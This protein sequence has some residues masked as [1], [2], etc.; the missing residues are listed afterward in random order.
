[1]NNMK[2]SLHA[3][4][5][6]DNFIAD[7]LTSQ[8][9]VQKLLLCP[10]TFSDTCG[11]NVI[12]VLILCMLL[13]LYFSQEKIIAQHCIDK[14]KT[15]S[16]GIIRFFTLKKTTVSTW[17]LTFFVSSLLWFQQYS[18]KTKFRGFRFAIDPI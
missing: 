13:W 5:R 2:R 12:L 4:K 7:F 14:N 10:Y 1:M 16:K 3:H 11:S 9:N 18:L 17:F 6:A 8:V 15:C